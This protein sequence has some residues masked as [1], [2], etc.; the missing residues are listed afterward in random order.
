VR[1]ARRI[2][3]RTICRFLRHMPGLVVAAPKD[4]MSLRDLLATALRHDGPMAI[5]YPRGGGPIPYEPRE[6]EILAIG[7]GER[8]VEGDDLAI[9]AVGSTVHPVLDAAGLLR[10]DGLSV[11]VI[12]ARFIKPLDEQLILSVFEK[13]RPVL[14]VEDNTIVGGFRFGGSGACVEQRLPARPRAQDRRA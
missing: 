13:G 5:R 11:E 3:A 7:K 8:L 6:I 14:I 2:K 10:E 4:T 12:D 1:T 9:I